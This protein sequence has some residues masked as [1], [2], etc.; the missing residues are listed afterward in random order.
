MILIRRRNHSDW[1]KRKAKSLKQLRE[2]Q[3]TEKQRKV[4]LWQKPVA[5][6]RFRPGDVTTHTIVNSD[7]LWKL[8]QLAGQ[9]RK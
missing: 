8:L 4:V 2:E 6:N 1:T 7:A 3:S 9:I 5:K